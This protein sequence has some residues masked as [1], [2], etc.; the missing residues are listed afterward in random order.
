MCAYHLSEKS[1]KSPLNIPPS[2]NKGIGKS[3][4]TSKTTTATLKYDKNV[5]LK[6]V[7]IV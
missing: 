6:K 3:K 2:F 5:T 7:Y 1:S 4:L